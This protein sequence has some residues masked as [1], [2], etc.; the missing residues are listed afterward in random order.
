MSD[1]LQF[2]DAA[3]SLDI[4]GEGKQ[5]SYEGVAYSGGD[6]RLDNFDV[7]VF[8]D[9]ASVRA[10][11]SQPALKGHDTESPVGQHTPVTDAYQLRVSAGRFTIDSDDS[12]GIVQAAKDGHNW[13]LSIGGD[14]ETL[15]RL[16]DNESTVVNGRT[17]SGP[18]VVAYGFRWRETSFVGVGADAETL[19][20]I[21]AKRKNMT[22]TTVSTETNTDAGSTG[23]SA[24]DEARLEAIQAERKRLDILGKFP[25]LEARTRLDIETKAIEG[26]WSNDRLELEALRASRATVG[27]M[28][29]SKGNSKAASANVLEA[30]FLKTAGLPSADL[31][32][33]FDEQTLDA[34]DDPRLGGMGIKGFLREGIKAAGDDPDRYG[35]PDSQEF[36]RAARSTDLNYVRASGF[37]TVSLPNILGNTLGKMML[38]AYEATETAWQ[39]FCRVTPLSDFKPATM[40][41]LSDK[42]RLEKVGPGGEL[43][44][45]QLAEDTQTLQADTWGKMHVLTRQMIKN[46]DIGAFTQLPQ[47]LGSLAAG[48]LERE[49]FKLFLGNSDGGTAVFSVGNANYLSGADS[50]LDIDAI[51]SAEAKFRSQT[52]KNGNPV[53]VRPSV[54]LVGPNNASMARQLFTSQTVVVTGSSDRTVGVNN[55]HAEL[56]TP[57]IGAFIGNADMPNTD[58]GVWA[59]LAAPNSTAAVMNIGFVDGKQTPTIETADTDFNVLGMGWRIYFDFGVGWGDYRGGVFSAGS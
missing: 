9:V 32:K 24:T 12:R 51:T 10:S 39:S 8:V 46:D 14:F 56:Y 49:V 41:R 50:A 16:N 1:S 19:V 40:L 13:Q 22:D 29:G 34:A 33:A 57:A 6:L 44:H 38:S 21:S 55:P 42:G 2:I 52:G 45:G 58:T 30:A 17:V 23:I 5:P 47:L 15:K 26:G 3:A 48:E 7:P 59:L 37:S 54:L 43:K 20:T 18:A 11:D 27:P 25:G 36:I 53:L 4:Q 31:E 28:I 35:S